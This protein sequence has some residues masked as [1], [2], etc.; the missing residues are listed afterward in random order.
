MAT[1]NELA[2][3][4]LALFQES[5]NKQA[6]IQ[7]I[8]ERINNVTYT[9]TGESLSK[10]DKLQLVEELEKLFTEILNEGVTQ[11]GFGKTASSAS[12]PQIRATDNSGVLDIISAIKK[13]VGNNS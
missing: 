10:S 3:G 11:K 9:N 6:A 4:Y 8:I 2:Q 13:G 1:F 5:P 7:Q 12:H